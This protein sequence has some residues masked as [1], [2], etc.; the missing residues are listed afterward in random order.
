MHYVYVTSH[1]VLIKKANL[2]FLELQLWNC[3]S[4]TPDSVNGHLLNRNAIV[5]SRKTVVTFYAWHTWFQLYNANLCFPKY[6]ID[7]PCTTETA[8]VASTAVN[9]NSNFGKP[10]YQS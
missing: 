10:L 4:K 2:V 8:N 9:C 6:P 7:C 1:S 3:L 5:V